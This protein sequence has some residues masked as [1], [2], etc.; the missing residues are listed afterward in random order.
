MHN[1][2][3]MEDK[4]NQ[5]MQPSEMPRAVRLA[6]FVT[7][8]GRWPELAAVLD[9]ERDL[10]LDGLRGLIT[11]GR[12]RGD[13]LADAIAAMHGLPRIDLDAMLEMKNL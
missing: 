12:V 2:A 1:F 5:R 11:D 10:S 13:V 7:A 4:P 3:A 8:S 9:G 6:G